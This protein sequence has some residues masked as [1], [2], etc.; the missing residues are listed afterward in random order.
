MT[1][2]EIIHSYCV[3]VNNGSGV[4]VNAMSHEYSYVLTAAHVIIEKQDGI[5]V[6][7]HQDNPITV[8]DVFPHSL[9][10]L[11]QI[12]SEPQLYDFAILKVNFQEH[13][14]QKFLPASELRDQS[15]LT[16]VGFPETERNSSDPIKDYTGHKVSVAN[17]LIIMSVEGIPG[18]TTIQG[19]SGGGVY[20]IKD[21]TPFLTG[22]EFQMDGTKLEQQYGRV[23]CHCLAKFEKLIN[24]SSS[25]PMIPPY[26]DC[27]SNVRDRIFSFNVIEPSNV[28]KLKTELEQAADYLIQQGLTPPYKLIKKYHSDLL[29]NPK[30]LND[31]TTIELWTAYLE[32]IVISVLIDKSLSADDNYLKNLERRRRLIYTSENANWIRSLEEILKKARILLDANGTLIVSSP[33]T[34]AKVLPDNF[35]LDKVISD[36][37]VVPNKG[38][39]PIIDSVSSSESKILASYKLTHLEGLRNTCVV[40]IEDEYLNEQGN[41][42]SSQ[43]LRKKLSEIIS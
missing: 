15:P 20:H 34:T 3:K 30:E 1:V 42:E 23:Q 5:I 21:G 16:L 38:P 25:A 35:R 28:S 36:I 33:Q 31:L 29:L 41:G 26:L 12:K 10:A 17:Q 13:I 7:D 32:F 27:F 14:A 11:E 8:L 6:H 2:S 22:I 9:P 37:T 19:M 18:K 4:L 39:F 40:D 43:L 24:E